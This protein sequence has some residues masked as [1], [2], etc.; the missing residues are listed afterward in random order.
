[1]RA[2]GLTVIEHGNTDIDVGTWTP[3]GEP[4]RAPLPGTEHQVGAD[5]DLYELAFYTFAVVGMFL[6]VMA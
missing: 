2:S 1:M 6:G 4:E 3:P 5:W